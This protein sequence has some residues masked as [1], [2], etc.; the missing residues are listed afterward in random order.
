M[1]DTRNDDVED[2]AKEPALILPFGK[3]KGERID[4]GRDHDR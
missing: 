2:K 4:E 3:H 1:S